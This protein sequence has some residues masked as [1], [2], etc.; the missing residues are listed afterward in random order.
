MKK[1][2]VLVS[3]IVPV[4]GTEEYLPKCVNSICQQTYKNL[5]IILVDDGSPDRCPSICDMYAKMDSRVN[6]I[7]QNNKG[8]SAARNAGISCAVGEYVLFVD[9]DDELYLDAIST[10]LKDAFEY[11]AD[12]VWAP[13][14][15]IDKTDSIKKNNKGEAYHIF[16]GESSLLLS[17]NG[18]YNINAV[19]SKLFKNSIIKGI[20]FDEGK[21]INEDGFFM[22]QTYLRKPMLVCHYV[23]VYKYNKRENSS[24][25]QEF[26]D[27]YFSMLH[28][29]EKKK[30]LI[31]KECPQ[32][33]KNMY[34]MEVR[35]NLQFLEVLCSTKDKKYKNT[36]KK[37]VKVVKELYKYHRPINEHHKKLAWIVKNGLYPLYKFAVGLKYYR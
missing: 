10:L 27:K 25:R 3:V 17:L 11:K 34:N 2:D 32:Y 13:S 20:Y 5:Q 1:Q 33:I 35:T 30:E 24:S 22:F 19:W 15:M 18:E 7:H 28:F 8:V 12:I 9:S 4:Y 16:K 31:L 23:T 6:V 29:C 26:S 14:K 36:H 37:S 21:D